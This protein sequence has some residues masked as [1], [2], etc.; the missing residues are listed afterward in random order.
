ML[1][2]SFVVKH[3]LV[4]ASCVPNRCH[5]ESTLHY[6]SVC[7]VCVWPVGMADGT[8][9]SHF[10]SLVLLFKLTPVSKLQ[11][12]CTLQLLS[13]Q[14]RSPRGAHPFLEIPGTLIQ[15]CT[16]YLDVVE[17]LLYTRAI[18]TPRVCVSKSFLQ[19]EV[20]GHQ[21]SAKP[22]ML[23]EWVDCTKDTFFQALWTYVTKWCSYI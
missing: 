12:S 18:R 9:S 14:D 23:S 15:V 6:G 4:K 8:E 13:T 10:L 7:L 19:A 2:E 22:S 3:R 16:K 20:R 17:S 21:E 11:S 1:G 5:W